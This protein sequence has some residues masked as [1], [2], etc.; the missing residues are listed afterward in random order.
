[1][2]VNA[3]ISKRLAAVGPMGLNLNLNLCPG[4]EEI[5]IKSKIKIMNRRGEERALTILEML[6][7]VS[8]LTLIVLG[9]SAMLI[10]VQRAFK[11]GL[12]QTTT[13]DAGRTIEGLI[14]E[15]LQQ[16]SAAQ[17]TGATNNSITNFSWVQ[18]PVTYMTQYTN[19]AANTPVAMRTNQ[20]QDIFILIHTN[21]A[22]TAVGYY[23]SNWFTNTGNNSSISAIGTLY[24]WTATTNGPLSPNNSFFNCFINNGSLITNATS[25]N[26]IADG[27]VHLMV[28]AYD[29]NGNEDPNEAPYDYNPSTTNTFTYPVSIL[30]NIS[31]ANVYMVT[32]TLPNSVELEVGVFEPEAF[33]QALSM[34]NAGN[35]AGAGTFLQNHPEK[36]DIYRQR[37]FITAAA[38]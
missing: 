5:K 24:R 4:P 10:Q 12:K 9:L 14:A 1:M 8:L 6:V 13:S 16:M 22:W 25:T 31:G 26:R 32:N 18:Y 19:N 21:T 28:R 36:V 17:S 3:T 37:I 2:R 11:A 30:T 27:I 38:Q 7:A 34:Y 20:L 23:V 33:Q 35:T 15:D 29:Q